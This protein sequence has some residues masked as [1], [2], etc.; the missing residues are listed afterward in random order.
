MAMTWKLPVIFICENNLYAMGTSVNRTSNVHEIYKLGLAYD[1]P[2]LQVNGMTCESVHEAISNA[3]E[4]VR[5]GE[6]PALLEIKTYRYKGHS[7][8]DPGKYRSKEELEEYKGKDPIQTTLKTIYEN[9]FATEEA[10]KTID[11]RV[12]KTV[13]ES[14]K[15]AEESAWPDNSEVLKDVYVDPNYP[16]IID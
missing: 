14:V 8:S 13:T 12:E 10:I 7:I 5:G 1:M 9:K 4:H 2:S 3:A 6:G 11:A 16:F 15:F